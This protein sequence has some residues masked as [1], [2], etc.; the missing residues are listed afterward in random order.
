MAGADCR[1]PVGL[2][3]PRPLG[4]LLP[5]TGL[6][7]GTREDDPSLPLLLLVFVIVILIGVGIELRDEI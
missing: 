5:R 1:P 2:R 3:V 4:L 7:C 6:S